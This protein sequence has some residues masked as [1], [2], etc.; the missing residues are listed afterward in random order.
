MKLLQRR[1]LSSALC[2]SAVLAYVINS[3][4]IFQKI[5]FG[6]LGLVLT[7]MALSQGCFGYSLSVSTA[8][9]CTLLLGNQSKNTIRV[10]GYVANEISSR[11]T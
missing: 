8:I 10:V 3:L 2:I 5:D 1:K 9:I 11:N 7:I 4:S 6:T